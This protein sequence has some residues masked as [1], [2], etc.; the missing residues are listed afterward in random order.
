MQEDPM[1]KK[2]LEFYRNNASKQFQLTG[3][4]PTDDKFQSRTVAFLEWNMVVAIITEALER[5]GHHQGAD[6]YSKLLSA[7]INVTGNGLSQI[8]GQLA[9]MEEYLDSQIQATIE[10]NN[11]I[12][13]MINM[14]PFDKE[15]TES[16]LRDLLSFGINNPDGIRVKL[17]D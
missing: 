8:C 13:S 10:E 12:L 6:E 15:K 7:E 9:S 16:S 5:A 11:G 14:A 2:M 3:N 4:S 1:F 17:V